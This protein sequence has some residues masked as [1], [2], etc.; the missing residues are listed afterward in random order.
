MNS[1]PTYELVT[2]ISPW[3][4]VFFIMVA[5]FHVIM[6]GDISTGEGKKS[7]PPFNVN[8]GSGYSQR[9]K[10]NMTARFLKRAFD[11]IATFQ[12]SK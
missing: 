2:R 10:V 12:I 3:L 7:L 4:P 9:G 5:S 8:V 6:T 11:T 1:P